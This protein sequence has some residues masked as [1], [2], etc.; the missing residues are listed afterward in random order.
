MYQGVA[1]Q[2]VVGVAQALRKL[3][4]YPSIQRLHPRVWK[5]EEDA[6]RSGGLQKHPPHLPLLTFQQSKLLW[7]GCS[8]HL[9]GTIG[10]RETGSGGEPTPPPPAKGRSGAAM[11]VV[12]G[13]E[14]EATRTFS[15]GLSGGSQSFPTD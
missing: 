8:P 3:N 9:E 12:N 11:T 1:L 15:G 14:R 7:K 13:H 4:Y 10:S 2:P 6:K 5:T